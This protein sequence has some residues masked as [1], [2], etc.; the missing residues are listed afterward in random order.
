ML[1]G[2]GLVLTLGLLGGGVVRVGVNV[3]VDWIVGEVG[4][5]LGWGCCW[6]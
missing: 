5:H 2:L 4:G 6:D 3:E 1:L